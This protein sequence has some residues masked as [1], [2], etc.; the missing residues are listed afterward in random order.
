[1]TTKFMT[2]KS[3][4]SAKW[5]QDKVLFVIFS[6]PQIKMK[7]TLSNLEFLEIFQHKKQLQFQIKLF[8]SHLIVLELLNDRQHQSTIKDRLQT[9]QMTKIAILTLDNNLELIQGDLNKII[10]N[11][12]NKLTTIIN[13]L[14]MTE[15]SQTDRI[16]ISMQITSIKF[17]RS[18]LVKE[19]WIRKS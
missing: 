11:R 19:F 8:R 4:S 12:D 9:L 10:Q 3:T 2:R 6:G 14:L 15:T 1:M 5:D 17:N 18:Q 16:K 7:S 13:Q